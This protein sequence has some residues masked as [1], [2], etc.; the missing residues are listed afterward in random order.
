MLF[1][2][3]GYRPKDLRAPLSYIESLIKLMSMSMGSNYIPKASSVSK[4]FY[5]WYHYIKSIIFVIDSFNIRNRRQ[6]LL[7]INSGSKDRKF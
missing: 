1:L 4:F 5:V 6:R 2:K 3:S 7:F